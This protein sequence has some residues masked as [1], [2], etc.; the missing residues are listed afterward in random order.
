MKPPVQLSCLHVF[1]I[2][3]RV[4]GNT[5]DLRALTL[6]MQARDKT[7]PTSTLCFKPRW[8]ASL[9]VLLGTGPR[10]YAQRERS[11]VMDSRGRPGTTSHPRC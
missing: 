1:A 5:R 6:G 2:E 10:L 7:V 3:N 9:V 4:G 11:P 8:A